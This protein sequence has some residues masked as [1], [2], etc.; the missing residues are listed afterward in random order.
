MVDRKQA[1]IELTKEIGNLLAKYGYTGALVVALE[2]R[3]YAEG[4]GVICQI[5]TL[6]GGST[7]LDIVAELLRT[8]EPVI[9]SRQGV[10][11][12]S[13]KFTHHASPDQNNKG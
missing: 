3:A 8:I 9:Q 1:Q 10:F 12:S 2:R 4:G 13:T 7:E 11:D 6:A 5:N